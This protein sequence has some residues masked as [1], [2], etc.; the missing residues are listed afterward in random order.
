MTSLP[1]QV[2]LFIEAKEMTYKIDKKDLFMIVSLSKDKMFNLNPPLFVTHK[3]VERGE[4]PT[5]AILETV[6]GFLNSKKLLTKLVELDYTHT[7]DDNDSEDL[8]E[9]E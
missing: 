3:E 5:I 8:K 6:L 2:K 7:Y 1:N 9:N 4:L